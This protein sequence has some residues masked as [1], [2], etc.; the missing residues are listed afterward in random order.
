MERVPKETLHPNKVT[1]VATVTFIID[2]VP[3]VRRQYA[4][5][6][7]RDGQEIERKDLGAA[8][9]HFS[10]GSHGFD[11]LTPMRSNGELHDWLSTRGPSPFSLTLTTAS[12]AIVQ[13]VITPT[14]S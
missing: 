6:L 3:T 9:V 10:I 1:G 13:P 5:V 11:F 14:N 8:G 7:R 12:G 4:A 2:D